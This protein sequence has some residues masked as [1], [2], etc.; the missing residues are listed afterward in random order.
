M[1]PG[2]PNRL[3]T[4]RNSLLPAKWIKNCR[5]THT[6]PEPINFTLLMGKSNLCL[7]ILFDDVMQA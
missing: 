3:I 7:Q 6:R 1:I 2:I 4:G 5:Q